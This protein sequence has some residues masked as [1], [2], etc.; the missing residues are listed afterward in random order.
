M[1]QTIGT[2]PSPLKSRDNHILAALPDFEYQ[3][4]A[5]HL[6]PVHLSLG[7][8]LANEGAP[9]QRIYFINTGVISLVLTAA[10]GTDVEVGLIGP[11]GATGIGSVLTETPSI[12]RMTVQSKGNAVYLPA[13]I[14]R[15]EFHH[16]PTLQRLVLRHLQQ[17]TI[18]TAQCGLCNRLH[19]VEQ[20]LARWLLLMQDR[21]DSAELELTQ[22]FIADMLGIRRSG[23]TVA[24]GTLRDMNIIE[25]RRGCITILDQQKLEDTACECY[26]EIT[27]RSKP[28]LAKGV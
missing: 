3:R 24:A 9:V 7:D 6:R 18:Q 15:Q 1:P 23:V 2:T 12:S 25:Y 22:E 20:R 27:R 13:D 11:E 16:N 21:V 14:F 5:P 17:L 4:L 10:E 19:T 26:A 8:I 28:L